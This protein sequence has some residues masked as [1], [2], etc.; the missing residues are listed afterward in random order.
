MT[1]IMTHTNTNGQSAA[2]QGYPPPLHE[3]YTPAALQAIP[4]PDPDSFKVFHNRRDGMTYCSW[5]VNNTVYYHPYY[6]P[7]PMGVG[8]EPREQREVIS[9]RQND[10]PRYVVGFGT[11]SGSGE[12]SRVASAEVEGQ[13]ELF[14]SSQND[15]PSHIVGLGVVGFE[16]QEGRLTSQG[17]SGSGSG[18]SS[19]QMSGGESGETSEEESEEEMGNR[20]RDRDP[21][22]RF[23]GW[24]RK[25]VLSEKMRD[26]FPKRESRWSGM[27]YYI[28]YLNRFSEVMG[29]G[30]IELQATKTDRGKSRQFIDWYYVSVLRL[31]L[32][33]FGS[34]W[35]LGCIQL[36]CI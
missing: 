23:A 9:R 14:W 13:R 27:F 17:T 4:V 30:A 32:V 31:C 22:W 10:R 6:I 8:L 3:C 36:G 19:R 12:A 24:K 16:L 33:I 7:M 34:K 21:R 1:L 29:P 20:L 26:A 28:G 11:G 35:K 18:E 25:V 2:P 5:E 15:P